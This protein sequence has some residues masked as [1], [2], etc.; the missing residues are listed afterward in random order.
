V[1]ACFVRRTISSLLLKTAAV[2]SYERDLLQST[3]HELIPA[4]NVSLT[5]MPGFASGSNFVTI[6]HEN[7][8]PSNKEINKAV[9]MFKLPYVC[10]LAMNHYVFLSL[11]N[12]KSSVHLRALYTPPPQLCTKDVYTPL[13]STCDLW[14]V[15]ILDT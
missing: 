5:S 10:S 11:T 4:R 14:T 13:G 15:N 7:I 9:T 6:Q 3:D 12:R 1:L 2:L 8:R